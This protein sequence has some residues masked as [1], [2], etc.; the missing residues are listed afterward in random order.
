MAINKIYLPNTQYMCHSLKRLLQS[1]FKYY[2]NCDEGIAESHILNLKK[3]DIFTMHRHPRRTFAVIVDIYTRYI[4]IIAL[5]TRKNSL[6]YKLNKNQKKI[7][8]FCMCHDIFLYIYS[9]FNFKKIKIHIF[10]DITLDFDFYL[11]CIVSVLSCNCIT[12]S[13]N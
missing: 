1:C 2:I 4:C 3:I 7:H 11:N 13:K 6:R 5:Q 8:F 9:L 12:I 10:N